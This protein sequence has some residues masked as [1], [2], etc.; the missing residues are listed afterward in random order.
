[1]PDAKI[2]FKPL[3]DRWLATGQ[4]KA[5][6]ARKMGVTQAVVTNWINRKAIPSSA[7]HK[8]ARLIG[9]KSDD[10]LSAVELA[11]PQTKAATVTESRA[12][13]DLTPR[14]E[15][16]VEFIHKLTPEQQEEMLPHLRAAVHANDITRRQLGS[17][18]KT[19]GNVRMEHEFGMPG[20]ETA[21]SRKKG[22]R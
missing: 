16:I 1:M 4:S 7:L 21:D 18:L 9:M 8:A 12:P 10:Y 3:L 19:I 14:E 13:Y 15:L 2:P 5:D 11:E 6:F 20:A 17:A 22:K